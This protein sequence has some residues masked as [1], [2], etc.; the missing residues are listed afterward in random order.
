MPPM[1]GS[2]RKGCSGPAPLVLG[3][4]TRTDFVRYQGAS[5]DMNPIHH[6]ETRRA[7]GRVRGAARRSGCSTRG[8]LANWA[9][10]WLG[11]ENVRRTRMRWKEQVWPGDM[12]TFTGKVSAEVRGER[13]AREWRSNR[14]HEADGRRRRPGVDDV[15][16][17]VTIARFLDC[18]PASLSECQT[19]N[20]RLSS[21]LVAFALAACQSEPPP[22]AAPPTCKAGTTRLDR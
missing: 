19:V 4:L 3:P 21:V 17:A 12:L 22:P 15:R 20:R 8:S 7:G 16:R 1:G 9:A 6:D 5:G 13:R 18:K 14:V 10:A 2:A 11:P